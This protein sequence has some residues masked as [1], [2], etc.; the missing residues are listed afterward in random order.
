MVLCWLAYSAY[1]A[2]VI[3]GQAYDMGDPLEPLS[4]NQGPGVAARC[5]NTAHAMHGLRPGQ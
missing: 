4:R 2:S 1:I 5:L 3:M